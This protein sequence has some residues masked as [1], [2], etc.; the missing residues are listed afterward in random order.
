[1]RRLL[2]PADYCI[3]AYFTVLSAAVLAAWGRM[4]RPL[5]FLGLHALVAAV[6]AGVAHLH[7]STGR[8][9]WRFAHYWIPALIVMVAFREIHYLAPQLHPFADRHWDRVLASIDAR[10]LGDVAAFCRRFASRPVADVMQ[11]CYWTYFAMPVVLAAALWRRGEL[12]RFREVSAV[13]FVGW[14]VTYLGYLAV[15][16]VGPHYFELR[17]PELDGWACAAAFHRLLLTVELEMPDA[18]P[19]GHALAAAL[20]LHLAWRHD[21]RVFAWLAFFAVGCIVAT[22][23]LR[24]HYVVDLA[25]SA[26]LVPVAI[27]GGRALARAWDRGNPNSQLPSPSAVE[28]QPN[29]LHEPFRPR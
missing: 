10:W 9:A 23:Y 2:L 13:Y 26:V 20:T 17:A 4:E 16:A 27:L 22:V 8:P 11:V 19:S 1:L 12:G 24:Y 5:L 28:P 7:R 21:R 3:F 15:P 14:Y 25:A 29:G 18:F 6:L